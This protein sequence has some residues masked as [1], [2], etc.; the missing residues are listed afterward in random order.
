M[1]TVSLQ[2]LTVAEME[3]GVV[4]GVQDRRFVK[5]KVT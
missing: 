1:H 4:V 5:E 3:V 2:V